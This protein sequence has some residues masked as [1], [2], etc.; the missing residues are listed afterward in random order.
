MLEL[1]KAYLSELLSVIKAAGT[2][3]LI[4][5]HLFLRVG[6]W[7]ARW[8][9]LA[10]TVTQLIMNRPEI[11]CIR[12]R[13]TRS[14]VWVLSRQHLRLCPPPS[15]NRDSHSYIPPIHQGSQHIVVGKKRS[16]ESEVVMKPDWI[17]SCK[18]ERKQQGFL[19]E[20][21]SNYWLQVTFCGIKM[22]SKMSFFLHGKRQIFFCFSFFWLL[23]TFRPVFFIQSQTNV[24]QYAKMMMQLAN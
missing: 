12:C 3:W 10:V 14:L 16:R 4:S 18:K 6:V 8:K 19:S 13:V 17:Y 9:G 22:T 2:W 1:I 11:V 5:T 23:K 15:I 24:Q 20:N 7:M 21:R